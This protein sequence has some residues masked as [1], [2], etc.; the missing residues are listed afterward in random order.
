MEI[1]LGDRKIKVNKEGVRRIMG[2]PYGGIRV[3]SDAE[4][5][6]DVETRVDT[7]KIRFVKT[8]I[9]CK[10]IVNKI[11]ENSY[12]DEETFKMDFA[13]L[14]IATM[15][16]CTNNGNAMYTMLR[17][18]YLTKEFREHDWCQLIIDTIRVCKSDWD[19]NDRDLFFRGPLTVLV[20]STT[21]QGLVGDREQA[22]ISY[23]TKEMMS[24]RKELKIRNRG[25][26]L[27]DVRELYADDQ[28]YDQESEDEMVD[29]SKGDEDKKSV[30]FDG[31]SLED[32]VDGLFRMLD[33]AEGLKRRVE[34]AVAQ[35]AASFPNS[36]CLLP[37]LERYKLMFNRSV[38][39]DKG[40]PSGVK[41]DAGRTKDNVTMKGNNNC[42]A[43]EAD[44]FSTPHIASTFTQNVIMYTDV[45]EDVII[46]AY[47]TPRKDDIP[48]FDLGLSQPLPSTQELVVVREEPVRNVD[49]EADVGGKGKRKKQMSKYGKSPFMLRAVD[50]KSWMQSKDKIIWRYLAACVEETRVAT[51]KKKGKKVVTKEGRDQKEMAEVAGS[52]GSYVFLTESGIG[53]IYFQLKD[54]CPSEW[55]G[56]A[57]INCFATVLN[58]EEVNG[59]K[60]IK[61]K[62]KMLTKVLVK[63][64]VFSATQFVF[65]LLMV[66]NK[67]ASLLK[68]TDYT[69]IV[70]PIL[71]NNHFYLISFDMEKLA[72]S[73]IDNMHAS[74][75]F[76]EFSDNPDFLKKTTPFKVVSM[77][78][79]CYRT[80]VVS[81]Q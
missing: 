41:S 72:I 29:L 24:K 40:G 79:S 66:L 69:V 30:G 61:G 51:P 8:P 35:V 45:L 12:G 59:R 54:F 52:K 53:L 46:G 13:M 58:Y 39:D 28:E 71:E 49:P 26:G 2:V 5:C 16:A 57:V 15:I 18:F 23:W 14:F 20:D 11:I 36:E 68:L 60:T 9:S 80:H 21:C 50:I 22:P 38:V 37:V 65:A 73:V 47:D 63:L 33:E 4:G 55:M 62:T 1:N 44:G 67:D 7:W 19:R 77:D 76:I 31:M 10:M 81:W 6:A 17:W 48:S 75:S 56:D 74:E 70:F 3:V 27:G 78:L 42:V 43:D 34:D 64:A 25:F 32:F